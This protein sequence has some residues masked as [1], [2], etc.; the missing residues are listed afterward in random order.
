MQAGLFYFLVD[1]YFVDFPDSNLL[2]NKEMVGGKPHNRPC[3]YA[4]RNDSSEIYWMIPISSKIEK[5][6][7]IYDKKIRQK[8]FCGTIVF[9]QVLGYKTAF[10]IQNMCPTIPRYI[11]GS[12]VDMN[13]IFRFE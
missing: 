13:A 10:L 3:F 1:D 9:G 8:G 5:Y 4:F 7:K 6:Q 2:R 11:S 12:Y